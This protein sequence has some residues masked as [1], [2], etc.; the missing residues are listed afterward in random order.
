VDI[1]V[2]RRRFHDLNALVS[3]LCM[4]HASSRANITNKADFVAYLRV[5]SDLVG[6][7]SVIT[8]YYAQENSS[9]LYDKLVQIIPQRCD[10]LRITI[11]LE[12]LH[13]SMDTQAGSMRPSPG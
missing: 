12:I 10:D 8:G 7:I 11:E 3:R 4:Q 5:C 1:I 9:L 2:Y 6:L 13:A